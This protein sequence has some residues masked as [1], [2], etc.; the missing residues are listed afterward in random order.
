M[1]DR[2]RNPRI[3][4][5]QKAALLRMIRVELSPDELQA[6]LFIEA[7]PLPTARIQLVTLLAAINECSAKSIRYGLRPEAIR[8]ALERINGFCRSEERLTIAVGSAP[9][10]AG[11]L[12]IQPAVSLTLPRPNDLDRPQTMAVA[13]V[14]ACGSVLT[15]DIIAEIQVDQELRPGRTVD[16]EEIHPAYSVLKR[17]DFGDGVIAE[18]SNGRVFIRAARDGTVLML[19]PRVDVLNLE[20]VQGPLKVTK[21]TEP[22]PEHVLVVGRVTGSG[23]LAAAG[24]IYVTGAVTGVNLEAGGSI[25]LG[26]A[27]LGQGTAWAKCEGSFSAR[28]AE[29]ASIDSRGDT[30]L[31]AGAIQSELL[32]GGELRVDGAI[33]GGSALAGRGIAARQ[34]GSASGS[35]TTIAISPGRGLDDD[36]RR[37][38]QEIQRLEAQWGELERNCFRLKPRAAL[39]EAE[40]TL[41]PELTRARNKQA[42]IEQRLNE[43]RGEQER[44]DAIAARDALSARINIWEVLHSGVSLLIGEVSHDVLESVEAVRAKLDEEGERIL[45]ESVGVAENED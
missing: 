24:N 3:R 19:P 6:D 20:Q 22:Y 16:G 40:A 33:I 18:V 39:T 38:R 10:S 21:A 11:E 15:G 36:R 42:A 45:F 2:K 44:Q 37:F 29:R 5:D 34:L 4:T 28:T 30:F 43:L 12:H 14:E 32:T 25:S 23:T 7:H 8:T 27:F 13:A 31:L 1:S 35:S 17:L 41:P 26:G 9:E